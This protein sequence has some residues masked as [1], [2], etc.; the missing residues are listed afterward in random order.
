[1]Q[2]MCDILVHDSKSS[3]CL[4]DEQKS[5]LATFEHKGANVTLHRSSKRW[6]NSSSD[7]MKVL[8]PDVLVL[9]GFWRSLVD[10][11]WV[12]Q[13]TLALINVCWIWK[14]FCA[15]VPSGCPWSMSRLF[16]LTL[17]S[18]TIGLMMMWYDP[19]NWTSDI[20]NWTH[21]TVNVNICF[22]C[23]RIW[24]PPWL[25][26][27]DLGPERRGW[28]LHFICLM[29]WRSRLLPLCLCALFC[30]GYQSINNLHLETNRTP[31]LPFTWPPWSFWALCALQPEIITQ[32]LLD[33][34]QFA[35]VCSQHG[36]T[37]YS[38]APGLLRNLH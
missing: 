15:V 21:F 6:D 38:T 2:L 24:T 25:N 18:A 1:M 35:Q 28:E 10:S 27:W 23:F 36:P 26:P 4:N 12:Q 5:L 22:S 14:G 16:C 37:L 19:L 31:K 32:P 34:L 11:Q 9:S 8:S 30:C 13:L 7:H 33:H 17:T 29:L 20:L 3:A